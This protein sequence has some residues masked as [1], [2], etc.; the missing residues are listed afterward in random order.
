MRRRSFRSKRVSLLG[1]FLIEAGTMLAFIA[2]AQPTWTHNVIEQVT[3]SP[4]A[5][6]VSTSGTDAFNA[7]SNIPQSAALQPTLAYQTLRPTPPQQVALPQVSAPA[8]LNVPAPLESNTAWNDNPTSH[9][10]VVNNTAVN[11]NS[12]PQGWQPSAT[13]SP[14]PPWPDATQRVA[15]ANWSTSSLPA[16]EYRYAPQSHVYPP[17]NWSNSY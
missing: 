8:L 17:S 3:T 15:Q 13:T 16:A 6:S 1:A 11:N 4:A 14:S 7:V 9:R 2:L 12:S 10:S 5:T